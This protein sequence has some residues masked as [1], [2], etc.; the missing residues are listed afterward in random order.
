MHEKR[1]SIA[2]HQGNANKTT[3]RRHLTPV[4]RHTTIVVEDVADGE[5]PALLEGT[6]SGT[7]PGKRR[8]GSSNR[9][10]RKM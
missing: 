1:L 8:A 4:R 9:Q 7:A 10:R 2:Y 6:Q 3:V 5:L